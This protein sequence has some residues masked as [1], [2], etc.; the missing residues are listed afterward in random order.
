MR[1]NSFVM[2]VAMAAAGIAVVPG[3]AEAVDKPRA[4]ENFVFQAGKHYRVVVTEV[5]GDE[6]ETTVYWATVRSADRENVT[7]AGGEWTHETGPAV[8]PPKPVL[9]RISNAIDRMLGNKP[10]QGRV[11]GIPMG[12]NTAV[13]P[14]AK[15]TQASPLSEAEFQ[16]RKDA[17]EKYIPRPPHARDQ[18]VE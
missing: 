13:V 1:F 9:L 5:Y 4:A 12:D 18:C 10:I 15:I 8:K 16:E 3:R 2:L 6:A 11:I 7:L 14:R 17:H